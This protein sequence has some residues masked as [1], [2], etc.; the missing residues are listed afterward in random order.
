[1]DKELKRGR[2]ITGSSGEKYRVCKLIDSGSQAEV[3]RVKVVG[4][5]EEKALKLYY[6][7]INATKQKNILNYLIE[8]GSID[9]R[10][11]MPEE[12]VVDSQTGRLGF[13][14]ELLPNNYKSMVDLVK[15]R[16]EPD[17]SFEMLV[18]MAIDIC[19]T[20]KCVHRNGLYYSDISLANVRFDPKTGAIKVIDTDNLCING[21]VHSSIGGTPKFQA[22][23]LV[24][25]QAY[26]STNTDLWALAV[27]LFYMFVIHHPLD[28]RVESNIEI[29]DDAA[30][31]YLYGD[32]AKFIYD[33]T[34]ASNRPVPGYQDNAIIFWKIIPSSLKVAFTKAFTDGKTPEKRVT[35]TEWLSIF[36]YLKVSRMKCPRC[37]AEVFY[38]HKLMMN[39]QPHI[40]WNCDARM[41]PVG[42]LL[43]DSEHSIPIKLH[44]KLYEANTN[45][46][47]YG[48]GKASAEVIQNPHNPDQWGVK[49]TTNTNWKYIN[50]NGQVSL[51]PMS[52]SAAIRD[53]AVIDFGNKKATIVINKR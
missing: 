17:P 48:C 4:T 41:K 35:E 21:A 20:F 19:E 34:D 39:N 23:E 53:G 46:S 50:P 36:Y 24:K 22:P 26:A 12:I 5:G 14:M 10:L 15:R 37:H 30:S 6:S 49:N 16:V 3:Y 32:Y 31:K 51:V 44:G 42:Y 18:D 1:M 9:K 47:A 52:K 43:F 40:C 45:S 28:G 33:P 2:V 7:T 11:V 27:L 38:D 8:R 25:G 13:T 29:I